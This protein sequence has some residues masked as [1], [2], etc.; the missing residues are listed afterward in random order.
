MKTLYTQNNDL[1]RDKRFSYLTEDVNSTGTTI[2]IQS[3]LG[4]ES[5]TTGSGQIVC[6]GEIGAE[7]TE[8]LRTSNATAPSQ[9]YK[10]ITLRDTMNFDHPQDTKV[11]ITDYNRV[12]A[13]W[14]ATTAGS[15][16][17]LFAYPF[18][19]QPDLQETIIVDTSQTTGFYF[20]RFN[21]S[22]GNTNSDWSDPIPFAGY[23]DNMVFSIKQRALNAV[24]EEIDGKIITHTFL[25]EALWTARREYHNSLGRRPFRRVFNKVIGTSL[26]G[27][28]RI[29]LP[30]DVNDK[31]SA[32]DIYGVRIGANANMTNYDKK[33]WDFDYR[34]RPHTIL[35][36]AYTTSAKD[37]YVDSARD[38]ADSGS[39]SVEGTSISYSAK[40]NTGGTLRIS[41]QGSYA[42]S[43]GSDVFQNVT[44]GLPDK[45]AVFADPLGSAYIYF[46]RPIDT[47]YVGMNI[48]ADYY[49]GLPGFDS[50]ADV[51]DEPDYDMYVNYLSYRIK[52]RKTRG[53]IPVIRNRQGG[54]PII[55]DA[56]FQTWQR[57]LN[58]VLQAEFLGAQ[59]R[60]APN[61]DHLP[62]PNDTPRT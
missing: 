16:S 39:V 35:T 19:L 20:I 15:K 28:Y 23:D 32:I 11:Y 43:A 46:N 53:N 27:S 14:A 50:D 21:E 33:E 41:T 48:F 30:V 18:Q 34:S 6:I 10:E 54:A 45:F 7:R 57:L 5:L 9:A 40:S 58:G 24:G 13:Q 8:L 56:D 60:I 55:A 25:N 1:T 49:R 38:L 22:V 37:L 12:E 51:L 4:F 42:A 26:T 47:A 44:T 52:E 61:V 3:I 31:A 17:T 62:M 2:R 36:T 29:D 59:I